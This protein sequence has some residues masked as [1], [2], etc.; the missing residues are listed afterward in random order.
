M[1]GGHDWSVDVGAS[2][3]ELADSLHSWK[4]WEA[5]HLDAEF[6]VALKNCPI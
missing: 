4:R 3:S 6:H 2:E 1:S 5:E